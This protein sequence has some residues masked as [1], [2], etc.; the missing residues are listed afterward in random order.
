MV[1]RTLISS[2]IIAFF[3]VLQSSILRYLPVD[4]TPDLAL[5]ALIYVSTQFGSQTGQITGFIT[6]FVEDFLS[7]SPF[8]FHAL[9]KAVMGFL[10]GLLK[11]SVFI[12]PVLFPVLLTLVGTIIKWFLVSLISALFNITNVHVNFFSETFLLELLL[13]VLLAPFIFAL[14]KSLPFLKSLVAKDK[15]R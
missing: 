4:V 1:K 10:Y 5:L 9:L 12:D 8:G 15:N 6:G 7:T 2:G 3:V 11:K 14:L 13:N